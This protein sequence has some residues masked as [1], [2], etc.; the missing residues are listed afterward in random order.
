MANSSPT[1]DPQ[2]TSPQM[3]D[4]QA[5][6]EPFTN[7]NPASLGHRA[8]ATTTF[9]TP[10][11]PGTMKQAVDMET[12]AG[13]PAYDNVP[14]MDPFVW[15]SNV[16]SAQMRVNK[17]RKKGNRSTEPKQDRRQVIT[18]LAS[19]GVVALG[20]LGGGGF[21]LKSLIE[22]KASRE[23]TLVP[24]PT[25]NP[26][27]ATLPSHL[28]PTPTPQPMH[29][30]TP[31]STPAPMP[32]PTPRPVPQHTGTVIAQ[33][34]MPN[35]SSRTFTNPANG[36]TSILVHLPNGNFVAYDI[37]CTHDGVSV[38]YQTDTHMLLCPRHDAL[39][40]PANN[41]NVVQGPPPSPLPK[42]PIRVNADGT[43][44]VG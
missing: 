41:A 33:T 26:E 22:K 39:F 15:W 25:P 1:P 29:T 43:V 35:N 19:G 18:L 14:N 24:T 4:W 36:N 7:R 31:V 10:K 30:P 12:T 21:A 11:A 40:D 5:Q 32:T 17:K 42:V 28:A 37:A 34:T 23:A 13:L 20:L 6:Q 16:G 3:I 9:S 2:D 44:T 38:V 27:G 8:N